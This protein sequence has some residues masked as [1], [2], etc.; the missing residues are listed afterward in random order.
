MN[1]RIK[2][3]PDNL[4]EEGRR[5]AMTRLAA[6]VFLNSVP[7]SGSHLLRNIVRMFVAPEQQYKADFIQLGN[8]TP[9]LGA[10]D[11]ARNLL[12]WGHMIFSD[13]PAVALRDVRHIVLYRDPYDWV[14]A[15][16]RFF[17]SDEFQ[18][19]LNN[20]K[21]GAVSTEDVLNLMIFGAIDKNPSLVEIFSMNAVAWLGSRAVPVRYEDIMT[22]LKALDAPAAETFFGEMLDTCGIPLPADWRERVRIGADRKHSGTSRENLT[23][24]IDIPSTLPEAQK[25]LIDYHAPGLRRML[26]YE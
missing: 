9:H 24:Q 20:I 21:G 7:K 14:L 17:L 5:F 16:A 1:V 26:G 15:R 4:D 19:R 3:Q 18:G 11:P 22:H 12:S 13:G 10:F 2:L 6:P 23:G 8:L 25:R